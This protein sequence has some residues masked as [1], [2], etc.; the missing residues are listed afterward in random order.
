MA[1]KAHNPPGPGG[2]HARSSI[3]VVQF[4]AKIRKETTLEENQEAGKL[5]H[6][7]GTDQSIA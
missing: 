5:R 3:S 1:C 6:E 7:K 4:S 2:N